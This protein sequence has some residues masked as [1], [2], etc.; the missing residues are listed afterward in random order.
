[1]DHNVIYG[2]VRDENGPESL[3]VGRIWVFFMLDGYE[4]SAFKDSE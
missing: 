3:R 1:M 2:T 4:M